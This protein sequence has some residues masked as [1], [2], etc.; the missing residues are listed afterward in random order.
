MNAAAD[1]RGTGAGLFNFF[2]A[3]Y[4]STILNQY[5]TSPRATDFGSQ[6]LD[7]EPT[8]LQEHEFSTIELNR[9]LGDSLTLRAK[10]SYETRLFQQMN[11]NDGSISIDPLIGAGASLGLPAVAGELCFGT[12]NF[13]FC[14]YVASDRTYDFSDVKWFA[15]NA[16][17]NIISDYDGPFNFTVGLY[18]FCLL[19]TSPSPR[20]RSSS[21]MPSSA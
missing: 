1:N 6:Y 16:E 9:Q 21:R 2:S 11:D 10:Y 3:L 13:G 7:R 18:S 15:Q 12:P 20:D 5:G 14:E 8:H 17:I 4:P 19:Y